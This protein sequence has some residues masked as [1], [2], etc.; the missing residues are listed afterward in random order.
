MCK[1]YTKF[2]QNL[3]I[4]IMGCFFNKL[5]NIYNLRYFYIMFFVCTGCL[6][7][8]GMNATK[9][10]PDEHIIASTSLAAWS[11]A[12]FARVGSTTNGWQPSLPSIDNSPWIQVGQLRLIQF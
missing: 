12:R 5:Y 7:P 1:L 4:K 11:A 10:I 6:E 3:Y 9:V 8:L 2:V